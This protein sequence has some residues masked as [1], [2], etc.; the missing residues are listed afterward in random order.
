MSKIAAKQIENV[1]DTNS[2]QE[3][4]GIKTFK[5]QVVF[6][7]IEEGYK[8]LIHEGFIYWVQD[9]SAIN[10]EGNYRIGVVEGIFSMQNYM[11]NQWQIM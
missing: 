4:L 10:F 8:M 1:L 5:S 6:D 3:V 7:Q 11:D 2:N 9:I